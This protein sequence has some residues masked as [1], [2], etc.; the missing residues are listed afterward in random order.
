[1]EQYCALLLTRF[2][3]VLCIGSLRPIGTCRIRHHAISSLSVGVIAGHNTLV[4]MR[5]R[6]PFTSFIYMSDALLDINKIRP[7]VENAE[8]AAPVA[9]TS[10]GTGLREE[11]RSSS[12]RSPSISVKRE[13]LASNKRKDKGK[14]KVINLDDDDDSV[15][16][17]LTSQVDT[18]PSI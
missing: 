7:W 16:T 13:K 9:S 14:N 18:Q 11:G 17:T 8:E 6:Q 4:L 1:M 12:D 10:R 2:L 15:R 5:A 3:T